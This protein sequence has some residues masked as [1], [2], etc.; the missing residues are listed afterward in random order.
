M[1]CGTTQY[2]AAKRCIIGRRIDY[3]LYPCICWS[4]RIL[5][6]CFIELATANHR[7]VST[8]SSFSS[9]QFITRLV[10]VTLKLTTVTNYWKP[11]SL[12]TVYNGVHRVTNL[13]TSA[14]QDKPKFKATF[15][16]YNL[17]SVVVI[18]H[19]S[20]VSG[21]WFESQ[22][23]QTFFPISFSLFFRIIAF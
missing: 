4:G 1:V 17:C 6:S 12:Y 2:C 9:L 15:I 13:H 14:Y 16:Y 23:A 3:S 20:H 10:Q 21:W 7:S 19:N 18:I 5:S 11:N 8:L 22:D